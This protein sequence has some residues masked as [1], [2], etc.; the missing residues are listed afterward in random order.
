M[1]WGQT[2]VPSLAASGH[3][4][5]LSQGTGVSQ[6]PC[7]VLS[8]PEKHK[9][10]FCWELCLPHLQCGMSL[11]YLPGDRHQTQERMLPPKTTMATT[12][13]L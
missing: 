8:L 10:L 13:H 2:Q 9:Q 1:T 3:R 5:S 4:V 11:N 7:C 6:K 12:E